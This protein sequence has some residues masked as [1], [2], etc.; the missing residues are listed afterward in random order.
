M[1]SNARERNLKTIRSQFADLLS[2]LR[3]AF[4]D[5]DVDKVHQYLIDTHQCYIP[6]PSDIQS[7]FNY[8][9]S[10]RFWTYHHFSLIESLDKHFLQQN[11]K[12][13]QQHILDYKK[14]LSGYFIAKKIISSEF[15]INSTSSES[16]THS[17]AEYTGEHHSVLRMELKLGRTVSE[18]SLK[19]VADLWESL[20]IEFELPSLTAVIDRIVKK[21]LEITWLI[22][23]SDA[24]KITPATAAR[25]ADFFEK[26]AITLL[27]ID[28]VI[29]YKKASSYLHCCNVIV[30]VVVVTCLSVKQKSLHASILSKQRFYREKS[31]N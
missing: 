17:V 21:C 16:T 3:E 13:I 7:F 27:T 2:R 15:F 20:A 4:D 12:T 1:Q 29:I 5:V 31:F 19:Y 22:F 28:D 8:L 26:H 18:K 30:C 25:H 14:E 9:S 11:D 6:H 24:E 10:K 23:P